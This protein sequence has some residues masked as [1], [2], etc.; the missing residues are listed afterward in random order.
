MRKTNTD[1]HSGFIKNTR[2]LL[3]QYPV[4]VANFVLKNEDEYIT[5]LIEIIN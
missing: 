5:Y 3:I 4:L 1:L 2:C